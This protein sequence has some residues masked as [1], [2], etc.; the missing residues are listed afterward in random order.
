VEKK[1]KYWLLVLIVVAVAFNAITVSSLVPWQAW[2]LWAQEAPDKSFRIQMADYRIE[3]P[4]SGIEVETGELTEFITTSG[5]VTYGLGVFRRDGTLVFQTQVLPGRE[6]RFVWK[7][8][9]AGS[10]DI[11]STEYSGPRHSEM[12][13]NDAITVR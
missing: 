10:Y 5:D 6:N 8:D 11:R 3:L 9:D 4:T 7:F 12:F 2:R 13:I 1:E